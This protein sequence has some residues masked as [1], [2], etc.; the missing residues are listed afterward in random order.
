VLFDRGNMNAAAR[1]VEALVSVDVR[2]RVGE[3]ARS[4]AA[5]I[6]DRDLAVEKV[7]RLLDT[8]LSGETPEPARLSPGGR[9]VAGHELV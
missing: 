9:L 5:R 2:E 4:L 6:F 3:N 7:L 8:V 1:G